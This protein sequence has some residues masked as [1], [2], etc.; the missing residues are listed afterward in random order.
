[1][2]ITTA[3]STVLI[4]LLYAVPGFAMTKT[5][6]VKEGEIP[7]LARLLMYVCQPVLVIS[8]MSSLGRSSSAVLN[9]VTVFAVMFVSQGALIGLLYIL[10]RKRTDDPKYR[11]YALACAMGN[12]SFMGIPVLQALL[13]DNP[14]AIAYS[15]AASLA[16]NILGWT[17]GS[18][19]IMKD[20]RFISLKKVF[21]NPTTIAA[22]VALVINFTGLSLPTVLS[23]A[24][25]LVGKMSTHLCMIIMGMRLATVDAKSIFASIGN[26]AVILVKQF[27][28]P[29]A[30]LGIMTVLRIDPVIRASCFIMLCCPSASVVLNF[31][32]MLGS[33][34]KTAAS[35]VLLSTV[36][37]IVSIPLM[38]LLI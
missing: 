13:P 20:S 15:A 26:Y 31:S 3:F 6:L 38:I 7:A 36:L 32:E 37:S 18:A 16:L 30:I 4:M 21:L 34:Q 1:M 22:A 17:V 10:M 2:S 33:G 12:C 11:I 9:L 29:A 14:E 28:F 5:G 8:S 23:D 27:A 19:V 25:G 35:I 24:V